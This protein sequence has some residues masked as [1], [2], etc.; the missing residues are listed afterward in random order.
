M[1]LRQKS[2]EDTAYDDARESK[3]ERDK[4]DRY[5]SHVI[6]PSVGVEMQ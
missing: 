5:G 3:S 6:Q 1:R 2:S 4:G